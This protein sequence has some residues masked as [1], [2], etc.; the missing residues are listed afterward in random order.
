[1]TCPSA[2]HGAWRMGG[3]HRASCPEAHLSGTRAGARKVSDPSS[4]EPAGHSPPPACPPQSPRKSESWGSPPSASHPPS[5]RWPGREARPSLSWQRPPNPGQPLREEGPATAPAIPL[6]QSLGLIDRQLH[7]VYPE[8]ELA[9]VAQP[10]CA[11]VSSS[12]KWG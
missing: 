4:Q 11:S 3:A 8:R 10:R 6:W 1:M 5:A 12:L 7:T 9:R 2:Q